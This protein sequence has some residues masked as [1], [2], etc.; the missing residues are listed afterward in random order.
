MM[1]IQRAAKIQDKRGTFLIF[2]FLLLNSLYTILS[3]D[4]AEHEKGQQ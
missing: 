3:N 4:L 1:M 2:F